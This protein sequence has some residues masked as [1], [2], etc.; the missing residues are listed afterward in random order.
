MEY[1]IGSGIL[2]RYQVDGSYDGKPG[3]FAAAGG[4][5]A[6]AGSPPPS[7]TST[8]TR[9]ASGASRCATP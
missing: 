6:Q 8:S 7:P 3:N 9:S 5:A 4:K 1:L 2:H